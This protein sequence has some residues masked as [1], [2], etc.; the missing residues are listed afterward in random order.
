MGR[1]ISGVCV[2]VCMFV[3]DSIVFVRTLR[4][5]RLELSTPNLVH[6]HFIGLLYSITSAYID[7]A[8]KRSKVKVTWLSNALPT[9]VCSSI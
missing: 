6:A 4:E 5:K 3:C 8:V 1:V 7:P 2:F 9:W